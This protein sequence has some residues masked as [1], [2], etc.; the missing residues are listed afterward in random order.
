MYIYQ[1]RM[2]LS[3][4]KEHNLSNLT[5]LVMEEKWKDQIEIDDDVVY[6][7][8]E[9]LLKDI[10]L[11]VID[12]LQS[13]ASQYFDMLS[14]DQKK[15]LTDA[16]L[17]NGVDLS[18]IKKLKENGEYL[19]YAPYSFLLTLYHEDPDLFFSGKVWNTSIV[20]GGED[21]LGDDIVQQARKKIIDQYDNYL[22]D[23]VSFYENK[24]NDFLTLQRVRLSTEFL[25]KGL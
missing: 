10:Q 1:E 24:Y 21:L 11:K 16:L 20:S 3:N 13:E 6:K 4:F 5:W 22:Q 18:E 15:K 8:V 17:Q 9:V 25:R 7:D 12:S 23:V 19:R 2:N 14:M